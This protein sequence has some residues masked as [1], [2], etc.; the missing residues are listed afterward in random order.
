MRSLRAVSVLF[1]IAL[2]AC[3]PVPP[4]HASWQPKL[5]LEGGANVG[6]LSSETLL[7]D[8]QHWKWGGGLAALTRWN[9]APAWAIELAP[10]CERQS[11]RGTGT[12]SLSA[13]GSVVSRFD[14]TVRF[15]RIVLPVRLAFRPGTSRW[16]LEGGVGAAWLAH[17][18]HVSKIGV[19]PASSSPFSIAR[20]SRPR[21]H[22]DAQIFEDLGTFDAKDWTDHFHRWDAIATA[23]LGWD[24]PVGG[25]TVRTRARWQQGLVDVAKLGGPV[26]LSSGS[27]SLGILW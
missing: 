10:G 7:G 24:Q 16:S 3:V 9:V 14:Q 21:A 19:D 1:V 12:I 18:E 4:V 13:G 26:R 11:R 23:G 20:G 22:P 27:L 5:G 15:D 6:Q 2:D 8:G 17:A 25:F